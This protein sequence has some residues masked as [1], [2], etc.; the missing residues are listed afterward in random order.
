M[1]EDVDK[2]DSKTINRL[3][4]LLDYVHHVGQLNQK[5]IFRIDEYKQ[6]SIWEHELK[7][8]IGIQHN[9]IDD[10][11]VSIWL[12]IERLKRLAPPPIPEQI[13]EW[14]AVGNDPESPPQIKEKVI[15]TLPEQEAKK[16][17]EK[18]IVAENDVTNPLKEQISEIKLK[19]V[20]FRLENNPQAEK[21]IDNYLNEHWRPWSEEE[22]PR[23]E[24][25]KIREFKL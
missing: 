8:K 3:N 7:G 15:K 10:D 24:T 22:K 20:I 18:G 21:D 2:M 14:V 13:Q 19:D 9:I 1:S 17:V 5:P 25:I 16:L 4:D 12:R 23:R 6:L 11:G